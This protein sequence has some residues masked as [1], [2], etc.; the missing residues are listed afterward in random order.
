MSVLVTKHQIFLDIHYVHQGLI[1]HTLLRQALSTPQ[2][3][4]N[5]G[6]LLKIH[7]IILYWLCKMKIL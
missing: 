2:W 1:F 7:E 4:V 3:G 6:T 5:F